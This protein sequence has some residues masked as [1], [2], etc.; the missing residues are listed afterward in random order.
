MN[1]VLVDDH[2]LVRKGLKTLLEEQP[3]YCVVGE[4]GTGAEAIRVIAHLQPQVAILD[5]KLPDLS[6]F[7]VATAAKLQSPNT[8]I[9]MLSMHADEFHVN[10]AFRSGADGYIVKNAM[11]HEVVDAICAVTSGARYV[12]RKLC[13]PDGPTD[14]GSGKASDPYQT[15]TK[16]EREILCM[17]AQGNK[18]KTIAERLFISCRTVETHRASIMRKLKLRTPVELI[19]FAVQRNIIDF[20]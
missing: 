10:E 3:A 13:T 20:K 5:I 14:P 8:R 4:A 6:G 16:R 12:S 17:I 9:I 18:N 2:P 19:H 1:I 7:Q 11:E 15:L